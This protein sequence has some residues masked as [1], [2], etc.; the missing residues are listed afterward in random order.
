MEITGSPHQD[1][2]TS[3]HPYLQ[4]VWIHS[5]VTTERLHPEFSGHKK[6]KNETQGSVALTRRA[7][8]DHRPSHLF[9]FFHRISF[10]IL[11]KRDETD[12]SDYATDDDDDGVVSQTDPLRLHLRTG[13][14]YLLC[15]FFVAPK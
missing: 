12:D 4:W 6:N 2:T 1:V 15:G 14:P 3:H 10:F 5:T 8:V 11:R 7:V 13:F 9:F